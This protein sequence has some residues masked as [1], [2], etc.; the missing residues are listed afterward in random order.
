[1]SDPQPFEPFPWPL[2]LLHP[3]RWR[4]KSRVGHYVQNRLIEWNW[5]VRRRARQVSHHLRK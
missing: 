5:N 2:G 1:M 4:P 3:G